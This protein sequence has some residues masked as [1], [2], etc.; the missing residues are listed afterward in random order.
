MPAM[1]VSI[2]LVTEYLQDIMEQFNFIILTGELHE[3]FFYKLYVII[4]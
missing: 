2:T 3:S 4:S 1:V